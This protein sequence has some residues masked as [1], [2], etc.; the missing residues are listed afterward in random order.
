MS[1]PTIKIEENGKLGGPTEKVVARQDLKG[2]KAGRLLGER[3]LGLA[4]TNCRGDV[5]LPRP[6]GLNA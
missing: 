5:R 1:D 3:L 6:R 4:G 2:K